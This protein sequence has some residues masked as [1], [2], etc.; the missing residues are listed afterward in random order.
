M[1]CYL[2]TFHTYRSWMPDH[3]RGFVQKGKGIQPT[4][5]ELS[6]SY[7]NAASNEPFEFD[8]PTQRFVIDVVRDM[9]IRHGWRI[10]FV[11]CEPTHVHILASWG[12]QEN[13][14]RVRAR[15]KN[16]VSLELS[17]RSGQLGRKWLSRGGSRKRVKDRKH[18][19]YLATV[20]L[21][22]HRG[23][24]WCESGSEVRVESR[25]EPPPPGGS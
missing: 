23:E 10:H 6:A 9:G 1:P 20:Y 17:K 8:K 3:P 4:N 13:W 12:S 22:R 24:T 15:I 25:N 19:D 21:P 16:I 14:P 2:F 18:F 11:A 7:R 5:P